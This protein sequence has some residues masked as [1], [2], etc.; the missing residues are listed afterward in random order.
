MKE[1]TIKELLLGKGKTKADLKRL[2]ELAEN[3]IKE[4][5]DFIKV[6]EKKL[7]YTHKQA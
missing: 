6:V 1:K 4:W 3:E 7:D 5:E 2:I